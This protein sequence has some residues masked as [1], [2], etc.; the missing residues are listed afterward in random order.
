M[1]RFALEEY[2]AQTNIV[3]PNNGADTEASALAAINQALSGN[4]NMLTALESRL[5]SNSV[6]LSVDPSDPDFQILAG[7]KEKLT[8]AEGAIESGEEYTRGE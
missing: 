3:A 8:A 1:P 7:L 4:E 6:D 2:Q 5:A